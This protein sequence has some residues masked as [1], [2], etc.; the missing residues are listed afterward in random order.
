[1][2]TVSPIPE[3]GERAGVTPLPATLERRLEALPPV[4]SLPR[5]EVATTLRA[6]PSARGRV[7]ARPLPRASGRDP[8]LAPAARVPEAD[9]PIPPRGW[10]CR[11]EDGLARR[12]PWAID[13]GTD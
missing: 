4:L 10:F 3:N 9:W 11:F 5:A 1:M 7:T 2:R 8:R 12:L 6:G 13:F